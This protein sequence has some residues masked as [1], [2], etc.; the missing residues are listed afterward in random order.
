MSGIASVP[1]PYPLPLL[2]QTAGAAV[3]R[4]VGTEERWG[5]SGRCKFRVASAFLSRGDVPPYRPQS[6][7]AVPTAFRLWCCVGWIVCDL[8]RRSPPAL[9]SRSDLPPRSRRLP[10]H[11]PPPN[12]PPQWRS[13][14][15]ALPRFAPSLVRSGS[16][17]CFFLKLVPRLPPTSSRRSPREVAPQSEQVRAR[18]VCA[19]AAR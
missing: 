4:R 15:G 3:A 19:H 12:A 7:P 2:H 16:F 11:V 17:R 14:H 6:V 13:E 9:S 8:Y 18:R 1:V 10:Q 5:S